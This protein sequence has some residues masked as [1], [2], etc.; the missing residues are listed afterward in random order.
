MCGS[1]RVKPQADAS[2]AMR[3]GCGLTS[4][5]LRTKTRIPAAIV[6]ANNKDA[7]PVSCNLLVTEPSHDDPEVASAASRSLS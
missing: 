5:P 6:F 1:C 3:G 4:L 2:I 7:Q